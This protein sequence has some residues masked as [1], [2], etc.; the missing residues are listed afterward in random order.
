MPVIL[1]EEPMPGVE[2]SVLSC[3][4]CGSFD[5]I[6]QIRMNLLHFAQDD[7]ACDVLQQPDKRKVEHVRQQS[8]PA[9]FSRRADFVWFSF[10][11]LLPG[12]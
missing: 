7:N 2:E 3:W 10:C 1:G 6:T 5:F 12:F 8:S 4:G 11:V 9:D